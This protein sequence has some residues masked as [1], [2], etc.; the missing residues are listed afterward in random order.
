MRISSQ[1]GI[2]IA[3]TKYWQKVKYHSELFSPIELWKNSQVVLICFP[4][5]YQDRA[6]AEPAMR[7]IVEAC[8]RKRFYVLS[9][10][11]L[12]ERWVNVELLR[13]RQEDLN[14]LS[15]PNGD[16]TKYI[17]EK[18]V[19]TFI[20]MWPTFNLA[21][22]YLSRR[23]GANLRVG[24]GSEHAPVFYNLLIVPDRSQEL[25]GRLY[26]TMAETILN[27]ERSEARRAP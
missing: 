23:C 14:F 19:G 25:P 1:S 12:P 18:C 16:F 24:F 7:A 27:L 17:Q 4:D 26:Q 3:L 13:L 15:L 11:A 2:L 8:P 21:N 9:T 22:A 6:V 20:D 5:E 10:K